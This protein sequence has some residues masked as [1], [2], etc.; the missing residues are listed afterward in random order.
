MILC[1]DIG[2][3]QVYGGVFNEGELVFRFR[4]N[5]K[6]HVSSDQFGLFLKTVLR[7]NDID[8]TS[9]SGISL[10]TVVPHLLY[11]IR[12]AC[13]KYFNTDPFILGPGEKTGLKINYR[14]PLE[15]GADRI[16]NSISGVKKFPDR[17]LIIVDFGTATTFCAIKKDKTYL[18]GSII[19]GLRL[20]MESLEAKTAK[21]PSV[22]IRKVDSVI[23]RSTVESL[24]SSLYYGH[25]FAVKGILEKI[26]EEYFSDD[27][28]IVIGTG[29]FAHLF[30]DEKIF[31]QIIPNLVLEGLRFALLNNR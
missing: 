1:L 26:T 17:N 12:N 13:L 31:H 21:L 15:V 29:G 2:N 22:E 20:S 24:Q 4:H 30:D 3:T 8:P 19:A 10:C 6:G 7:E 18:G 25:A 5:S 11:T 27:A 14:N 28:P 23:G 16:A 9:I